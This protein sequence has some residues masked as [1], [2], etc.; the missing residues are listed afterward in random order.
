VE[1][2]LD[3]PRL[4][5]FSSYWREHPPAHLLL[6]AL[7]GYKPAQIGNNAVEVARFFSMLRPE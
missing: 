2:E 5:A 6:A 3:I 4:A 7:T 1:E